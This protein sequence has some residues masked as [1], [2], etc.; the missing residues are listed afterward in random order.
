MIKT[1]K[2]EIVEAIQFDPEKKEWPKQVRPWDKII[3]RDMSWGFVDTALG[4]MHI[5]AGDWIVKLS[6]GQTVLVADK[7]YK[8]LITQS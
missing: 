2:P 1:K 8:S 3:P 4:R 7:N 5:Q 6:T